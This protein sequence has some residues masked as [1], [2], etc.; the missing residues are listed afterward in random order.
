[1]ARAAHAKDRKTMKPVMMT[2]VAARLAGA[3]LTAAAGLTLAA[4]PA[5][6]QRAPRPPAELTIING[7]DVAVT[8]FEIASTGA[9]PRLVGKLSRPLA[10]GASVKLKLDKPTG[11]SFFVL[12][13]FQDES[14]SESEGM[15]LCGEKQIRLTE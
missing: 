14:E 11:C 4:A 9:Q 8:M 6:A 1:M 3:A 2:S 5:S 15:N 7:R 10:P 12:A 13:R